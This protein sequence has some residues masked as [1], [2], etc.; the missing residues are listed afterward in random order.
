M[1]DTLRPWFNW[2]ARK[3]W[4]CVFFEW[5]PW[6]RRLRTTRLASAE[7]RMFVW[8]KTELRKFVL[9]A[10]IGTRVSWLW[11]AP[12]GGQLHEPKPR[13][14]SKSC[15]Q[16]PLLWGSPPTEH[17]VLLFEQKLHASWSWQDGCLSAFI[18]IVLRDQWQ[19]R[20][21]LLPWTEQVAGDAGR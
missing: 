7:A 1:I 6:R 20:D 19:M 11:A 3:A 14:G 17:V 8:E 10:G 12:T 18:I 16:S 5:F 15:N 2:Q 21:D 13:W 4:P 9:E